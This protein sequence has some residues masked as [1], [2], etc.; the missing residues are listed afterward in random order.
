MAVKPVT[1]CHCNVVI[2]PSWERPL[3]A[4]PFSGPVLDRTA[5]YPADSG[6]NKPSTQPQQPVGA[7]RRLRAARAGLVPRSGGQEPLRLTRG[8][9]TCRNRLGTP[10]HS[11]PA[12]PADGLERFV[13]LPG[14]SDGEPP[15]DP[16]PA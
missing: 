16:G 6:V 14:G 13:F 10:W 5:A 15:F 11:S 2:V 9:G 8:A 7:R 12:T 1:S 4:R 3:S